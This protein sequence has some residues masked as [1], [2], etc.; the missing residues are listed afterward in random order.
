[1]LEEELKSQYIAYIFSCAV[2]DVI[3][4]QNTPPQ[5]VSGYSM[6]IYAALYYCRA[7]NFTDGLLMIRTA[8]DQIC[9]ATQRGNHGMGMIVG[10]NEEDICHLDDYGKGVVI[11]NRNNPHTYIITGELDAVNALLS[12]AREEG[13][14]QARLLPVTKP[15][16]SALLHS[17]KEGFDLAIR[18]FEIK[19]PD[20]VYFSTV[21]MVEIGTGNGLRKELVQNIYSR[22]NWYETMRLLIGRG[23]ASFYECGAGDGLTKNF[24]FIDG[25][26]RAY[27]VEKRELFGNE[28]SAEPVK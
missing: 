13:A 2:A 15:Y 18:G 6:G 12:A 4:A 14:L 25:V 27:P 9:R 17:A 11:C 21:N 8:W 20:R 3:I 24:R 5:F 26:T 19:D 16:H 22:M 23:I 1:M 28:C 10:L 7:Y